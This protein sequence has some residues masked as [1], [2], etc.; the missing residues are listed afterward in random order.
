MNK[1]TE[2]WPNEPSDVSPHALE[3]FLAHVAGCPFHEK[4]LEAEE[5]KLR[6]KFRLARGVDPHAR[7]L[8]GRDL[9]RT[10]KAHDLNHVLWQQA[11]KEMKRPFKRIYVTNR[12]DV[13]A[14]S[15]KFFLLRKY[16]GKHPLDPEAGLQVWGVING[17]GKSIPDVLL[18]FYPL[19][20]VR[21]TGEEQFLPL[22][23][24][25]TVGLRVE[26][27]SEQEFEIGFRCVENEV[28]ERERAEAMRNDK[29]ADSIDDVTHLPLKLVRDMRQWA[30]PT[31]RWTTARL[32]RL[33]RSFPS[34][35]LSGQEK[36]VSWAAL[37]L[38]FCMGLPVMVW[39]DPD[40]QLKANSFSVTGELEK[41][42]TPTNANSKKFNG[43]RKRPISGQRAARSNKAGKRNTANRT[44]LS[45]AAPGQ[46]VDIDSMVAPNDKPPSDF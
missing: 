14:Q 45:A 1:C 37:V 25:Y 39:L 22:E 2:D 27:V 24:G 42:N 41:Q 18:G 13:I 31:W 17:E 4:A 28:L 43:K 29:Q 35:P 12:G 40:Q 38:V 11:A 26:Q 19:A 6:S 3:A 32:R 7:I 10:L 15:G 30:V 46:D 5:E 8:T 9:D 44:E 16:E 33:A 20:G 36:A 21:H 34:E 23:N